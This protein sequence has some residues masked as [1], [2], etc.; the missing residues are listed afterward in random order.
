MFVS[1]G[2][3]SLVSSG[4]FPPHVLLV[5]DVRSHQILAEGQHCSVE[6]LTD[7]LSPSGWARSHPPFPMLQDE[8]MPGAALTG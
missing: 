5:V 2:H 7:N 8:P 6:M 3:F 1:P 4:T